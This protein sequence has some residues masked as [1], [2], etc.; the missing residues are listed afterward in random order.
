[1]ARREVKTSHTVDLTPGD[2]PR[3]T[4]MSP[5][6]GFSLIVAKHVLDLM[7]VGYVVNGNACPVSGTNGTRL[8]RKVHLSEIRDNK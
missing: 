3:N 4:F 8:H 7:R 6:S 2:H 5:G 1:M